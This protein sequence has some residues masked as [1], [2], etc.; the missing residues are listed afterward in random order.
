M[1]S[2]SSNAEH[3]V[4]GPS[5][6]IAVPGEGLLPQ[7]DP[8]GAERFISEHAPILGAAASCFVRDLWRQAA[9][10][11]HH[12]SLQV[13]QY[14]QRYA[15]HRLEGACQQALLYNLRG[16]AALQFILAEETDIALRDDEQGQEQLIFPFARIDRP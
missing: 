11:A 3:R 8:L 10:Q 12:E 6:G 13:L 2:P 5:T 1:C 15:P 4:S 9:T 14:A 7:E 16:L